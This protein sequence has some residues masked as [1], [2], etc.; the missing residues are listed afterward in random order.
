MV[1]LLVIRVLR[2]ALFGVLGALPAP[3]MPNWW[4]D[5]ASSLATIA[6]YLNTMNAWFPVQLTVDIVVFLV[7]AQLIAFG[8]RLARIVLS[9]FTG[10]G[11]SAA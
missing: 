4:A 3:S 2:G 10:G 5:L 9:L 8:I 11:G 6:G 7:A 1:V